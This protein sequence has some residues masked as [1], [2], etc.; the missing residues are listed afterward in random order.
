[1]NLPYELEH[2]S[3]AVRSGRNALGWAQKDLAMYG[4]NGRIKVGTNLMGDGKSAS[5]ELKVSGA[6]TINVNITSNT[7]ISSNMEPSLV[8]AISNR[9]GQIAIQKGQL[10]ANLPPPSNGYMETMA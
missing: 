4:D 10:D 1:M 3:A 2:F 8:T 5:S 6:A 9:I 7:P